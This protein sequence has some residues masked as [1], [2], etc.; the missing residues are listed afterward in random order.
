MPARTWTVEQPTKPGWWWIRDSRRY[1][2]ASV[3]QGISFSGIKFLWVD[4]LYHTYG[5]HSAILDMFPTTHEWS[6]PIDPPFLVMRL[7]AW[8]AGCSIPM[9]QEIEEPASLC[10][11]HQ[12]CLKSANPRVMALDRVQFD[13][14]LLTLVDPVPDPWGR[15]AD[16]LWP[17]TIGKREVEL[18]ET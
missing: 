10:L 4:A 16:V 3:R 13:A 18:S 8:D 6:G 17:V 14:W 9:R 1:G 12:T 5:L 15:R 2:V 11:W 7:C